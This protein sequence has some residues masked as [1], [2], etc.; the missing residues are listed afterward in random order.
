MS[1]VRPLA[2]FALVCACAVA[3]AS[4]ARATA[5]E[6]EPVLDSA[7]LVQPALL[8]GPGYTVSPQAQLHGYMARLDIATAYGLI[9]AD[10]VEMLAVREAELPALEA[11]DRATR[12]GAFAHAIAQRGKKTGS[13]LWNVVAHPVDTV[14]G[15]PGG[16]ARYFVKKWDSWTHRA[17]R[18][19]D[20]ATRQLGNEGDPYRVPDGPMSDARAP[21]PDDPA[22]PKPNKAWYARAGKEAGREVKRQLDFAKMRREMARELGID[23]Y[24]SNE[25]VNARLDDLAWA[26]V[27]GN[28]TAKTAIGAVS[29]VAGDVISNTGK[30]DEIVW[31]LDA[32]DLKETNRQRLAEFCS[33][34]YAVRQFLHRGGFSDSLR[35]ALT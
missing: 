18:L 22:P 10:S 30:L 3:P 33:D 1:V 32:E 21:L 24:T 16:V 19:S 6:S 14:A 31:Q 34:D 17:Q 26:A 11:L 2:A 5:T 12:T 13:A 8:S 15:L 7:A 9:R 20:R 4:R 23:P 29:G 25:L 28:F 35:T 27:A